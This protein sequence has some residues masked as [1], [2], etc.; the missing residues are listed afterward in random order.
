MRDNNGAEVF[1]WDIIKE[2]AKDIKLSKLLG[3]LRLITIRCARMGAI[4]RRQMMILRSKRSGS[5]GE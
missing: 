4:W 1:E 5:F 2:G 3:Y